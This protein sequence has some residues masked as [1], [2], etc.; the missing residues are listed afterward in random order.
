MS[1][2]TTLT[3]ILIGAVYFIPT[4]IANNKDKKNTQAIFLVNL[5]LGWTFIGWFVALIWSVTND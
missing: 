2:E 3:F 5:L 4:I 1:L